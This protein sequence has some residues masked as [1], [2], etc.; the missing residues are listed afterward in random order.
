MRM[1]TTKT[2][3]IS[4]IVVGAILR[5][6]NLFWGEPYWFHPDERNIASAV[7]KLHW[8]NQMNPEFF[9]YGTVPIYLN[10]FFVYLSQNLLHNIT[11]PFFIA[12]KVGRIL[13]AILSTALIPLTYWITKRYFEVKIK[14]KK[15]NTS[16]IATTITTFTV[17]YIQF[18]HF[19]TFEIWLTFLRLIL[20]ILAI[21]LTRNP[22]W[23][24]II[25]AG[26]VLGLS[27]GTKVTSLVL[28]PVL[29]LIIFWSSLKKIHN[30][31]FRCLSLTILNAL[32]KSVN[33]ILIAFL[34]FYYTNPFAFNHNLSIK[35]ENSKI[36][37]TQYQKLP[38]VHFSL[39]SSSI[40][41]FSE[42]TIRHWSDAKVF[43]NPDFLHSINVEGAIARGTIPTFYTRHFINTVPGFYQFV[44]VYPFVLSWPVLLFGAIGM[45]WIGV[46]AIRRL[47]LK[48]RKHNQLA[49]NYLIL[50]LF[51]ISQIIFIFSLFVKWTRYTIPTL[52][53]VIISF[54]IT[55]GLVLLKT[56]NRRWR[57]TSALEVPKSKLI[58]STFLFLTITIVGWQIAQ[59][60]SFMPVYSQVDPRIQASLWASEHL[61]PSNQILSE[62]WD[63]GVL[64]LN[65]KFM[66]QIEL[67]KFYELDDPG[68]KIIRNQELQ[69]KLLTTDTIVILSRRV[70]K[71][72]LDFPDKF[73][74]SA[75]FYQQ[76]F[77]HQTGYS[78]VADFYNQP[79]PLFNL[80]TYG[81]LNLPDEISA[82]ET[83]SVFDHPHVQV[84]QKYKPL[85]I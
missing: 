66:K 50:I 27:V 63:L 32:L 51:F 64:P 84:W 77:S 20:F 34:V 56:K 23:R 5:F 45:V 14:N 82:E 47:N 85:A 11:D 80:L 36:V 19:G 71:H 26:I 38:T 29:V 13:S 44:H 2:I 8:P 55:V 30:S 69:Q 59:A 7:T 41:S 42:T 81:K 48:K 65:H 46:I 10:Y 60:L 17:G 12:I 67:F 83:F 73:S 40:P 16:L 15:T 1:K 62:A 75:N 49:S 33:L 24:T 43:L 74:G 25:A 79:A 31:D 18:A 76:L 68:T 21:E 70:W 35:Y 37:V 78:M 4:L 61:S 54:S 9:A 28:L 52:P 6:S 72:S 3:L 22:K 58:H 39:P 57:F 53:Y